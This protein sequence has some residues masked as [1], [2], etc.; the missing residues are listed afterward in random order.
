MAL[1]SIVPVPSASTDE[2]IEKKLSLDV[3]DD[4]SSLEDYKLRFVSLVENR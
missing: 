4:K 2:R 1:Y 3:D